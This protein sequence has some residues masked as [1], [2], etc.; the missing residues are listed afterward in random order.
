MSATTPLR[1]R[2]PEDA[3]L[4]PPPRS[5]KE[6]RAYVTQLGI[7]PAMPPAQALAERDAAVAMLKRALDVLERLKGAAEH[8]VDLHEEARDRA[9]EY[10]CAYNYT[11]AQLLAATNMHCAAMC[12]D[13]RL[14]EDPPLCLVLLARCKHRVCMDYV[15]DQL[16]SVRNTVVLDH[17]AISEPLVVC[18]LCK[19]AAQK[20]LRE[21]SNVPFTSKLSATGKFTFPTSEIATL[22]HEIAVC[23]DLGTFE[24]GRALQ[25]RY[26]DHSLPMPPDPA[27]TAADDS[28]PLVLRVALS[29]EI[30]DLRRLHNNADDDE[31]EDS[32]DA[33]RVPEFSLDLAMV[34]P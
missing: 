15:K 29:Q 7:R 30:A 25:S 32:D 1:T 13:D 5:A 24:S 26:G 33:G 21:E 4:P 27:A 2:L 19:G 11:H 10:E 34:P 23:A 17:E 18:P 31:E 14:P 9:E 12:C 8:I 20:W 6:R 16:F 3:E 28:V 22:R